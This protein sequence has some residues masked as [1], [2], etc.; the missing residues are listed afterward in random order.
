MDSSR[1]ESISG[2]Q[3]SRILS[4]ESSVGQ[5]SRIYYY[6]RRAEGFPFQWEKQPGTPKTPPKEDVNIPPLS[7]P[8]SFQSLGLPKPCFHDDELPESKPLK[9]WLSKKIKKLHQ[10]KSFGKYHQHD[11]V[12][13]SDGEFV[14][15]SF[16][17]SSSSSS[18][19]STD[20]FASNSK[21]REK[22]ARDMLEDPYCWNLTSMD[23]EEA[24]VA[25]REMHKRDVSQDSGK[26][27]FLSRMSSVDQST[28]S[29]C[30]STEGIPFKWEMQ[31]GTPIHTPQNEVIPPPSPPPMVQSL[32]LPKP[33]IPHD[34]QEEAKKSTSTWK[35]IWLGIKSKRMIK[36]TEHKE[37]RVSNELSFR[38][39]QSDHHGNSVLTSSSSSSSSSFIWKKKV[40]SFSKFRRDVFGGKFRFNPWKI[41]ANLA[42]ASSR[43]V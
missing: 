27:F 41:K 34:H 39:Q 32:A 37:F 19:S 24:N 1:N 40:L 15:S 35:R 31:P 29:Y 36:S 30:R 42:A 4:R 28:H 8:P 22:S 3:M 12:G 33:C 38:L 10:L 11:H 13:E 14:A 7:P 16:K 43:R 20:S 9:V 21:E 2:F 26:T 18:S 6:R 17:N 5:S 25:Y 23:K